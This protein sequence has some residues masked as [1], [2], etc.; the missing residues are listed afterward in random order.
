[1]PNAAA[2]APGDHAFAHVRG[3][4]A[5]R[6][7]DAAFFLALFYRTHGFADVDV[8][9]SILGG[10]RLRLDV[11]EGPRITIRNVEFVGNQNLSKCIGENDWEKF[12]LS[13]SWKIIGPYSFQDQ[14]KLLRKNF[15]QVLRCSSDHLQH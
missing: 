14:R 11:H 9:Y 10:N 4:N 15:F 12:L 6:A 8:K 3:G 7:D 2:R 1:M 5:T 13:T